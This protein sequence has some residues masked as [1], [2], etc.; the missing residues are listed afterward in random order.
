MLAILLGRADFLLKFGPEGGQ[1]R[2][3]SWDEEQLA[4]IVKYFTYKQDYDN[5]FETQSICLSGIGRKIE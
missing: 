2:K 5:P 1:R 3:W 4:K